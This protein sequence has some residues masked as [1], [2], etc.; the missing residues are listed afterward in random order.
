MLTP[1]IWIPLLLV[2]STATGGSISSAAHVR[3]QDEDTPKLTREFDAA[4]RQWRNDVRE[5]KKQGPEAEKAARAKHPVHEF[6]PRFEAAGAAGDGRAL[7]WMVEACE[8]RLDRRAD[9]VALKGELVERLLR[10]HAD[11]PWAAEHVVEMLQRQKVHFDESWVRARLEQ[12]AGATKNDETAAAAWYALAQRL[13]GSKATPEERKRG[14]E[15]MAR[16]EKDY[17]GTKTAAAL[18]EK[19]SAADYDVGGKPDFEAV[20]AD[21]V[22]F[23]LSDYRGKV[24]LLD[25]W[26]FW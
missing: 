12:L 23:K 8:D 17:A 4:V 13:T 20:D 18:D 5:A 11:A 6:W 24:V 25:F 7:V 2:T 16:I 1:T 3:A 9:V 26:G 10:E 14:E 19:K 21:G 22:A 15:L